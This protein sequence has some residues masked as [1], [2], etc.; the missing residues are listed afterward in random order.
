[1]GTVVHR[2]TQGMVCGYQDIKKVPEV[3]VVM[4]M[5]G[6]AIK[7]L[8]KINLSCGISIKNLYTTGFKLFYK[9]DTK[10]GADQL[11]TPQELLNCS[12]AYL[13]FNTNNFEQHAL[14][15][16]NKFRG[17]CIPICSIFFWLHVLPML[18][19]N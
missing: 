10:T 18:K 13:I 17:F 8:K 15:D 16:E 5:D 3:Q 6:Q 9:N 7:L 4:D 11:Y 12:K 19:K 14:W 2:F 1:V